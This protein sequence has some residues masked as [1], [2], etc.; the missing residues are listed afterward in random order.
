MGIWQLI[1]RTLLYIYVGR[2]CCSYSN[3]ELHIWN[4]WHSKHKIKLNDSRTKHGISMGPTNTD[5]RRGGTSKKRMD[6]QCD[7]LDTYQV[8]VIINSLT[9]CAHE[10]GLDP[11]YI[12][13]NLINSGWRKMHAWQIDRKLS[14]APVRVPETKNLLTCGLLSSTCCQLS[15]CQLIELSR[16]SSHS[17]MAWH[18]GRSGLSH[19]IL[20]FDARYL[21]RRA[22][23]SLSLSY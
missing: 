21:Q 11:G 23:R 1:L 19:V 20:F 18:H 10:G 12:P 9:W 2:Y 17:P 16:G 4:Q 13:P 3:M 7:W 8:T 5:G 22:L 14:V 6:I 15:H